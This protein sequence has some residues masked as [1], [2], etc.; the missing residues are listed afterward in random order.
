VYQRLVEYYHT[1]GGFGVLMFHMGR[2]YGSRRGRAR[3]MRLFMEKVAPRLRTLDPD[4]SAAKIAV[5]TA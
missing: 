4:Q 2:D 1:V 5:G 3:S